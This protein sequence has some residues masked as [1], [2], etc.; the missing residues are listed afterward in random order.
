MKI[1]EELIDT[2]ERKQNKKQ[3][4]LEA[5]IQQNL[6]KFGNV[7]SGFTIMFQAIQQS[8]KELKTNNNITLIV[9][10]NSPPTIQTLHSLQNY[11]APKTIR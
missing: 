9:G 8:I 5:A 10:T 3:A 1:I 2:S 11:Q 4:K 7:M 6:D